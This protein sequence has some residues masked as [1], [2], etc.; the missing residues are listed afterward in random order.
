MAA[1]TAARAGDDVRDRPGGRGAYA[2]VVVAGI[3]AQ[4]PCAMKAVVLAGRLS[5]AFGERAPTGC[6]A[7]RVRPM[8]Q[9]NAS[10]ACV[11]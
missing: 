1:A 9:I 11:C 8:M 7:G 3:G 4:P 6:A 5:S 2:G 10:R